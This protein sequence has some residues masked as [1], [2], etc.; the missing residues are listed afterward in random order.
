MTRVESIEWRRDQGAWRSLDDRA[1]AADVTKLLERIAPDLP[2]VGEE[3]KDRRQITLPTDG[4]LYE[5]EL[6]H[7][8]SCEPVREAH[9]EI[10]LEA[11]RLQARKTC[12]EVELLALELERRRALEAAGEAA[13]LDVGSWPLGGSG[14]D[15]PAGGDD[16]L[17]HEG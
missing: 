17:G 8:S 6:A 3:V 7:C 1:G 12:L 2:K 13:V 11:M 4:T 5:A 15:A 10:E 16:A 9:H 14:A